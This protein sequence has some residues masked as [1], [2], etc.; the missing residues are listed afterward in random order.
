M[1]NQNE[2]G[3]VLASQ[4][5]REHE[6]KRAIDRMVGAERI[7]GLGL[8]GQ[9]RAPDPIEEQARAWRLYGAFLE[10]A[11]MCRDAFATAK[12]D[13]P[14]ALGQALIVLGAKD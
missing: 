12:L 1:Q 7:A 9:S 14:N 5:A 8:G 13:I 3:P 11:R 10:T 6:E 4:S 2:D